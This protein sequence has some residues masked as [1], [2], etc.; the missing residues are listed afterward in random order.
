VLTR[1]VRV[2]CRRTSSGIPD[3]VEVSIL[4]V[5]LDWEQ[6]PTNCC[7][8]FDDKIW[9]A[10]NACNFCGCEMWLLLLVTVQLKL[11]SWFSPSCQNWN[12]N[13]NSET[14]PRPFWFK[15]RSRQDWIPSRKVWRLLYLDLT[16]T[17]NNVKVTTS[18]RAINRLR[19]W[20]HES[21]AADWKQI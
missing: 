13:D 5:E 15:R 7:I 8:S 2:S 1:T 3:T 11:R 6:Y 17:L 19:R 21:F 14:R 16:S 18:S 9:R 20:R 12:I 10:K 4:H